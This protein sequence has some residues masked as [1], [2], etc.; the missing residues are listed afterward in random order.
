MGIS[1]LNAAVLGKS[2]QGDSTLEIMY[3]IYQHL[4]NYIFII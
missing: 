2:E 4:I 3:T 1:E